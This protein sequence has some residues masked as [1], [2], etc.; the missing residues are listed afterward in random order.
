MRTWSQV[1]VCRQ[2]GRM[3][4]LRAPYACTHSMHVAHMCSTSVLY[5]HSH[6]HCSSSCCTPMSIK[7]G[8]WK[9]D[10]RRKHAKLHIGPGTANCSTV[11]TPWRWPAA[12]CMRVHTLVRRPEEQVEILGS[13]RGSEGPPAR[14]HTRKCAQVRP[15]ARPLT[16]CAHILGLLE[17]TANVM[18]RPAAASRCAC[19]SNS[20]CTRRDITWFTWKGRTCGS[21]NSTRGWCTWVVHVEGAHLQGPQQHT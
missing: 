17:S 16:A 11:L 5:M 1:R 6:T 12:H 13:S 8:T 20:L 15:G 9:S 10:F 2:K 14:T 21:P 18:G 19:A 3:R 7:P 4:R